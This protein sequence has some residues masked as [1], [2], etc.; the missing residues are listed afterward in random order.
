MG[1]E[2]NLVTMS[3]KQPSA[4]YFSIPDVQLWLSCVKIKVVHFNIF[5][6]SKSLLLV[7]QG[8]NYDEAVK[9]FASP[10][11]GSGG[12]LTNCPF[13]VGLK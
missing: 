9:P 4:Y 10:L 13:S 12:L 6:P 8:S 11:D 1:K 3:P 7:A 5:F 2:P